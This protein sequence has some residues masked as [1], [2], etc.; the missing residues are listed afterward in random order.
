M[1]G[2][3]PFLVLSTFALLTDTELRAMNR[4]LGHPSVEKQMKGIEKAAVDD[5]PDNTRAQ[6]QRIVGH[7]RP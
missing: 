6:L 5:L 1:R 3:R 4:K 7:C 2:D